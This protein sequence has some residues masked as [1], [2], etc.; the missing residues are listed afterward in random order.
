MMEYQQ[1][2]DL[3]AAEAKL[4]GEWPGWEWM[5]EHVHGELAIGYTRYEALRKINPRQYRELHERN[6]NGEN[7]D[8]MVDA[9]VL[10][11]DKLRH[12]AN[13]PNV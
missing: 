7:F 9:L 3:G 4:F 13:N 6:M 2:D 11:N 10:A 12:G 1:S 5:K 8:S